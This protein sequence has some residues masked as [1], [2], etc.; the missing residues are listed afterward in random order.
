MG[1]DGHKEGIE[2]VDFGGGVRAGRNEEREGRK[3]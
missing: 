3:Y 2:A 1:S